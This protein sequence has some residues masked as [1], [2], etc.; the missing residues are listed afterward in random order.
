MNEINKLKEM[1]ADSERIVAFTGAGISAESGI[2]T[3]RGAGGLWSRYDPSKYANI[4][5]FLQDS[6]YYWSFFRDVRYPALKKA[7]PNIAH[8][9]LVELEKR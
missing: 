5:Y 1:I 9:A 2:P 7:R 3:Y 6:T 8:F 4:N